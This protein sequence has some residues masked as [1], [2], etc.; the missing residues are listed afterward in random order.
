MVLIG[1]TAIKHYFNDFKREPHDIDFIV[2]PN[3]NLPI[4]NNTRCEF[5]INP[6]LENYPDYVLSPNHI[7]TLKVSHV[8]W[9]IKWEKHMFDIVFLKSKGCELD[10]KMFDEL[11]QYWEFK[12]G[13]PNRSNLNMSANDFFNNAIPKKH[14]HDFLH[15]LINPIPVYTKILKD[16]AEVDVDENKFNNLSFDEK[17][18]LVREEVYVMAYERLANRDYR[19]AYMWMLKK[20]ILNHA[21]LW[22]ALFIIENYLNFIKPKINYKQK[23]DYELSK[24]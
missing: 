9:D 7:Y 8:F 18:E 3:E 13:K 20:F 19:V 14:N 21:P 15:T 10:K 6:I 24:L 12:H 17:C 23:L 16:G 1:S 22:E 11:Y 2:K 4:I 5:H